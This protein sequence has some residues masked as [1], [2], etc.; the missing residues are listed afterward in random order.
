M[1]SHYISEACLLLGTIVM[2][3]GAL[4]LL[5]FPD[6]FTRTHAVSMTDTAGAGFILLGLM[7]LSG[8]NLVT[9]KLAVILIFLLTTSPTAGH[10]LA[11]AATTDGYRPL[12]DIESDE[13]DTE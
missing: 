3:L 7:V 1:I 6:F 2:I 10:A 4:G 5:R 13:T 11:Q 9:L 12:G 8:L